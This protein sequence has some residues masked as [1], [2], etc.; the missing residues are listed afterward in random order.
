MPAKYARPYCKGEKNDYR[1]RP[2]LAGVA[3]NAAPVSG[4]AKPRG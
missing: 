2:Q 3:K 1:D 4:I